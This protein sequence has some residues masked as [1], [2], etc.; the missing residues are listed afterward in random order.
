MSSK[1]KKRN[2][3]AKAAV[4]LAPA[5]YSA[6][7]DGSA[8]NNP[9]PGGYG[10]VVR[11]GDTKVT[12]SK[13]YYKT[14]N[15]RMEIMAVIATLEEFGP[16]ESFDIYIDSQY[17]IDGATMWMRGW[18]RNNWITFKT[19]QPVKNKDL[20]M[21]MNDLL[22][23]NKVRFIKVK[24]HSGIPDNEEADQLAKAAAGNPEVHDIEYMNLIGI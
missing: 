16:N 14:T 13:G 2:R 15:N 11:C 19:Q 7:T 18:I 8:L 21:I 22:K 20:W 3:K 4:V 10:A 23:Q 24:A 5:T 1:W 9:G 6:Y 12:L 17:V